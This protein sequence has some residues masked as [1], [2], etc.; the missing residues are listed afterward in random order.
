MP[1]KIQPPKISKKSFTLILIL[2]AAAAV[3]G[4]RWYLESSRSA[5]QTTQTR[6]KGHPNAPIQ[7]SEY[8]DFQ[9]SACAAGAKQLKEYLAQYPDKIHL[10]MRYYPLVN[11]HPH[12]L[13]AARYAQCAAK[14]GKF[15]S[16][17]DLLIERQNEWKVLTN[18]DS[19]FLQMAKEVPLDM[20]SLEVCLQD[21]NIVK[22][23]FE[24]KDQGSSL[25]VQSTPTYFIN[26]KMVVGVKSLTDML[27]P[28]LQDDT[29][30]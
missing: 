7:I 23:I 18:A 20:K 30:K 16:L 21:E 5:V 13:P 11:M 8:I 28:L 12:A 14:Q 22:T 9:C 27:L 19:A 17:H 1:K 29:K 25:G 3:L 6:A 2:T 26:G 10:E 24:E 15:W 4:V